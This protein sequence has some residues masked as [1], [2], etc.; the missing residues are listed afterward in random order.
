MVCICQ[1]TDHRRVLNMKSV[2]GRIKY[3]I[4]IAAVVPIGI[5]IRKTYNNSEE[6]CEQA[7]GILCFLGEYLPDTLYAVMV[8]L[9][10]RLIFYKQSLVFSL[11]MALLFCL[12]IELSQ[13][14]HAPWIDQLRANRLGGLVLGFSFLWS[15]LLCYSAGILTS[16][17]GDYCFRK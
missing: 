5:M 14:Y 11:S 17:L 3:S 4:L 10:L 1:S 13:L 16:F 9:G 2:R 8:Y 7:G 15:D 6:I 12:G